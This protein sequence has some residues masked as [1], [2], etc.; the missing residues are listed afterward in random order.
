MKK[1]NLISDTVT[2]PTQEMLAAMMA[3]EVGDDVFGSDPSVN[4]L[5]AKVAKMFGMEASVFCPSGTMTNQIA[6]KVHTNPLDEMICD[7]SSHVYQYEAGGYA[8]NSGI[9]VNLIQGN[10]GK[11]TPEQIN[12]AIKPRYD[13]LPRTT[14]VV[15]ENSCNKGGGSYYT[16]EEIKPIRQL[17]QQQGLKLHLDGARLFN[18]IV[19]TEESTQDIGALFDSVSICISKGLGAPVGSLLIGDQASISEAR[20]YRKVMGGGM[21]QAGYLAA[22]CEYALDHHVDRLRQDNAAAKVMASVLSNL[23]YVEAVKPV[24]TN[25]VIYSLNHEIKVPEYLTHLSN[26]GIL[27]SQFG[28]HEVRLVTHLDVTDDMLQEAVKILKRG[29]SG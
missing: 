24:Y 14:L 5:E 9:A 15:L 22:A 1:I 16:L 29:Y 19:E 27:A 25:I 20:R 11:I 3:A 28:P 21:R 13:W 8:Y 17:C 18:V 4:R 23:D 12:A 10:H 6:I 7:Y 2:K 26:Q